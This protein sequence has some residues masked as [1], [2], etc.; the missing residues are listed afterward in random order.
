M[1]DVVERIAHLAAPIRAAWT[2]PGQEPRIVRGV[3][4]LLLVFGLAA[5]FSASTVESL[6]TYGNAW[7]VFGK[8]ALF[9]SIGVGLMLFADRVPLAVLR[10]GS[11]A[12]MATAYGLLILVLVIG[13]S[14]NGQKNWIPLGPFSVQPSEFAKLAFIVFAA[15]RVATRSRRSVDPLYLGGPII[16]GGV[17]IMGL[18]LLEKD[19]GNVL[20]FAGLMLAMLFAIGYPSRALLTMIG[21]GLVVVVAFLKF[22]S[23]YRAQR[24][25]NWLDPY[26]DP[27]GYGWQWIRGSYALAVG[28]LLGQGPGASK[29]KWGALPEAHTDFILAVIGEEYGFVGTCITIGL[30]LAMIV[31]L[32]RTAIRFSDDPFR[33]MVV[34]G[35]AAWLLTQ[36]LFNIGAVLGLLPIIGVTLPLVSYGGSSLLPMLI[37]LGIVVRC[38]S[39]DDGGGRRT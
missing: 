13:S 39:E 1:A 38:M 17:G 16:I 36:S 24:I 31:L 8:Q 27:Q 22:G 19:M 4:Y 21:G 3:T 14:I 28:G 18:I 29:E 20:V 37:A 7:M 12:F 9:A 35:V 11:L 6:N 34:V 30:I 25:L 33:R 26:A 10:R 23:E 32:L 2:Q 5:V 15:E